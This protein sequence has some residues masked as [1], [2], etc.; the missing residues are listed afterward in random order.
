M[1]KL[2]TNL[3]S[4]WPQ[5]SHRMISVGFTKDA[6]CEGKGGSSPTEF[7][8]K[9]SCLCVFWISHQEQKSL[10]NCTLKLL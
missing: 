1:G 9:Y 7:S 2:E 6:W 5:K 8:S 3:A 10:D 4:P